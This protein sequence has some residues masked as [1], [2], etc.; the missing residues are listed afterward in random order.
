MAGDGKVKSLKCFLKIHFSR[1]VHELKG[2]NLYWKKN[3]GKKSVGNLR[4][5]KL[6]RSKIMFPFNEWIQ[7]DQIEQT[8]NNSQNGTLF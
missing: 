1:Y 6:M 8:S 4:R 3:S 5:S 7:T 2:L